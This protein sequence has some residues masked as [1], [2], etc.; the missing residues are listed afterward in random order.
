VVTGRHAESG[1]L[2]NSKSDACAPLPKVGPMSH[3]PGEVKT[4]SPWKGL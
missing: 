2:K 1:C 3:S 4:K